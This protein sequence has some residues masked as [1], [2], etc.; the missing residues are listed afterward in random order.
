MKARVIRT[1]GQHEPQIL[2]PGV[3]QQDYLVAL[4]LKHLFDPRVDDTLIQFIC[5]CRYHSGVKC[6]D[7]Y[8]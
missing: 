5:D 7:L 3:Q 2:A 6:H 1:R 4:G 8:L